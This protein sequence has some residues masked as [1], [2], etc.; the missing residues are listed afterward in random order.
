MLEKYPELKYE[1]H[2]DNQNHFIETPFAEKDGWMPKEMIDTEEGQG[3][4]MEYP[5][6]VKLLAITDIQKGLVSYYTNYPLKEISPN[7]FAFD[8]S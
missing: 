2:F 4:Y 8:F 3:G 7:R 6:G 5:N 1:Y